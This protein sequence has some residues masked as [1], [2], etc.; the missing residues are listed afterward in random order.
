MAV[1]PVCGIHVDEKAAVPTEQYT[2]EYDGDTFYFCSA[3]CK[4]TFDESPEQY[5][6]KSA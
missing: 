6:Q 5:T 3:G 1:D 4:T 2:S